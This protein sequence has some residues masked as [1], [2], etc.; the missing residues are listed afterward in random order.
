[1]SLRLRLTLTLALALLLPVLSLGAVLY[2]LTAADAGADFDLE[3]R[4]L[5]RAYAQLAVGADRVMLRE[6]PSTPLL[7][8]LGDLQVFLVRPNG[9]VQDALNSN[10]ISIPADVL[11]RVQGGQEASFALGGD[12]G[13]A[14]FPIFS[15]DGTFSLAYA[16]VV[17]AA[18]LAGTQRLM[19]LRLTVIVWLVGAAL[20]A[21]IVGDRLAVWL[22][23]PLREVAQTAR[24]V[25][26]GELSSRIPRADSRDELGAL[27]RSLNGMLERLESLV[28]AQ[29]RFT[30]EAAHDLRTP[31]S[32]LR[33]EVEVAL[34]RPRE[35]PEY[36]AVLERL[37]ERIGGLSKLAEDL[38]TLARLEAGPEVPFERFVLSDALETVRSTYAH[39][40]TQRGLAYSFEIPR[41]LEFYG[42]AVMI[43]RAVGNLLENAVGA[44]SS[45][46]GLRVRAKGRE[47]TLRVWDDG[48]GVDPQ[49]RERLFTRFAKGARSRGAG[50][51]LAIVQGVVRAHEGSIA[52]EEAAKGAMFVVTL[53]NAFDAGSSNTR[54][55]GMR[56]SRTDSNSR[57]TNVK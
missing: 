12:R 33:T 57:V 43:G 55:T 53:P 25:E 42:D 7:E 23:R 17:S 19:K 46:V 4:T 56:A 44:A 16:L 54:E 38:L 27:K 18:D 48:S 37:L 51:G 49:M 22:S 1:M 34:R 47:V 35:A 32:V 21:F 5:A 11:A 30:A 50:L 28:E 24:A 15:T 45:E 52:L 6:P 9:S 41:D 39:L 20:L 14:V 2:A 29:R 8:K 36:R 40:A 10:Q 13:A 26:H 3:L 31:L